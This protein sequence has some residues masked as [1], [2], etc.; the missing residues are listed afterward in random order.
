MLTY[1]ITAVTYYLLLGGN[2]LSSQ[3]TND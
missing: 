3:V 2:D 1:S